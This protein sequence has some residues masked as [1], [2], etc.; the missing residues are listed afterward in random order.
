VVGADTPTD[1]VQLPLA[2]IVPPVS[3]KEYLLAA[4]T[5]VPP[6]LLL[7]VAPVATVICPGEVG[8]T[9]ETATPV[10]ALALALLSF[11]VRVVVPF[12]TT[13]FGVKL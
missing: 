2:G 4:I 13:W 9:S 11:T 5:A 7:M 8:K 1:R 3:E 12:S 6:Q 10:M